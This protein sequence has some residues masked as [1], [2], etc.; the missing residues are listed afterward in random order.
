MEEKL[1]KSVDVIESIGKFFS[2][3]RR[4]RRRLRHPTFRA[5]VWKI[6]WKTL[7]DE[8][9]TKV[10]RASIGWF[11]G[12][13]IFLICAIDM[14]LAGNPFA[15]A[16]VLFM[17]GTIWMWL[18]ALARLAKPL[19]AADYKAARL[20]NAEI[21]EREEAEIEAAA[22]YRRREPNTRRRRHP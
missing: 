1:M 19:E 7:R 21:R 8:K 15:W 11:A 5:K 22:N 14:F 17:I 10:F 4:F 18:S 2:T 3:W 9:A 20:V 16:A 13:I 12:A 6:W